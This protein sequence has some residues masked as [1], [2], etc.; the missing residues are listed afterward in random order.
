MNYICIEILVYEL[1]VRIYFNYLVSANKDDER[2]TTIP[3]IIGG[4]IRYE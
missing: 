2:Q 1:H 4:L 3:K